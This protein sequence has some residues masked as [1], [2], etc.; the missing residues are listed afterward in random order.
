M[1]NRR[2]RVLLCKDVILY[3]LLFQSDFKTD[4][5]AEKLW[6]AL[7][8]EQVRGYVIPGCLREVHDF[9]ARCYGL[10]TADIMLS[11]LQNIV[12]E[13]PICVTYQLL[14][15]NLMQRSIEAAESV[16]YTQMMGLDRIVGRDVDHLCEQDLVRVLQM[17][18]FVEDLDLALITE[19]DNFVA[20]AQL[21]SSSLVPII[22][23][24]FEAI[25]NGL[26]QI[27]SATGWFLAEEVLGME[28]VDY[29]LRYLPLTNETDQSHKVVRRVKS[30]DLETGEDSCF[31][32][33]IINLIE[34]ASERKTTWILPQLCPLQSE[35]EP[36]YL[37]KGMQLIVL[38]ESGEPF[39]T[40][41]AGEDSRVLQLDDWFG[42]AP[43]TQFSIRIAL[44]EASF[45]ESFSI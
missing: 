42:D 11:K 19:V 24:W 26:E 4:Y 6:L 9:L 32:A 21:T 25:D 13:C 12:E 7:E 29:G 14:D 10:S 30:I 17:D 38:D 8:S 43:G 41:A 45:T 31:I 20:E 22:S 28:K 40:A 36:T 1:T 15:P 5:H 18:I 34:E 27:I 16:A 33:L 39:D 3:L 44:G 37:P 23:Q 35:N 2:E